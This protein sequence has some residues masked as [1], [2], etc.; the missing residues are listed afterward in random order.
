MN[1]SEYL[2]YKIYTCERVLIN[3]KREIRGALFSLFRN[4]NVATY[5][6]PVT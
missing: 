6:M 2:N 4:K 1:V 5:L 3:E